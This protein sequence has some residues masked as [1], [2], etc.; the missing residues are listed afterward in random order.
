MPAA[1][2][3]DR[4]ARISIGVVLRRQPGVTR[5]AKVVWSVAAVLPGAGPGNW[6]ELR[7]DGEIAEFHAA[8]IDLVLHRA[9]TESYL[10]ALN[11]AR[12]SVYVILRRDPARNDARPELLTVTASAFEAQDYADN[13]EDIVEPVPMPPGLEAWVRDFVERH[14]RDAPFIK[15]QRRPYTDGHRDDGIGDARIRQAADVYRAPG[16]IRK[17]D[18]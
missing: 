6:R 8:T 17:A 18:E 15:R 16:S 9:D 12:P 14:H 2:T 1:P 7:R 5:W 3:D 11:G 10:T 13:G 4:S